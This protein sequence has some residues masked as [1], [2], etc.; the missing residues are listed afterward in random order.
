MAWEPNSTKV[1]VDHLPDCEAPPHALGHHPALFRG[2]VK[3][4]VLISSGKW[5][6]MCDPCFERY[7]VGLGEGRGQR[8]EVRA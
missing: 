2:K 1:R 6:Y 5:L 7:G 4:K 8:L 3:Q